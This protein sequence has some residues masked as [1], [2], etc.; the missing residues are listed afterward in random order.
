MD[1]ELERK[2][3]ELVD[4]QEIR[5]VVLLYARAQERRDGALFASVFHPD[6]IYEHYEMPPYLIDGDLDGFVAFVEKAWAASPLKSKGLHVPDTLTEVDGDE[7]FAESHAL[8]LNPVDQEGVRHD[9]LRTL[10]FLDRFER[11]DGVWK[12]AHRLVLSGG[13]ERWVAASPP[14]FAGAASPE[15]RSGF[16]PDDPF[17]GIRERLRPGSV[18][19]RTTEEQPFYLRDADVAEAGR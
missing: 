8:S 17:Y 12:I 19:Q 3:R 4:K 7:A 1:A 18:A 5:E 15:L 11:R 10:R 16:Y 13:Y 2:L 9:Y 14:P 6:A